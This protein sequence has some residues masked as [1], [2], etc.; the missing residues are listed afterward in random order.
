MILNIAEKGTSTK[1]QNLILA[2][3]K[4]KERFAKKLN[5]KT[6]AEAKDFLE[7][8]DKGLVNRKDIQADVVFNVTKPLQE[9]L[10]NIADY[11]CWTVQ[12]VFE[13]GETRYYDFVKEKISVVVDLYDTDKYEGF[14]N[15]YS[16]KKPLTAEN[17]I[18]PPLH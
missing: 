15:Y 9:P 1:N 14:Q 4:A 3:E 5:K 16:P 12:R 10:L 2:L 8:L 13:K 18:S 6:I 7:V 11:L 17:K